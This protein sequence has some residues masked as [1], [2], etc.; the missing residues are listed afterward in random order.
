MLVSSNASGTVFSDDNI[1]KMQTYMTTE[2]NI[3]GVRSELDADAV[4]ERRAAGL[5]TRL[6]NQLAVKT[7]DYDDLSA[8]TKAGFISGDAEALAWI[9]M[10]EI[11]RKEQALK[12]MKQ[13]LI[14]LKATGSLNEVDESLYNS[15]IRLQ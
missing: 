9:D 15:K 7:S 1:S 10:T 11:Q 8:M 6:D 3:T 5:K 13:T 2:N 4:N 14:D 12:A